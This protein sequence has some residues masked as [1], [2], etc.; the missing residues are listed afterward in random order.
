MDAERRIV[1]TGNSLHFVSFTRE[2]V[3]SSGVMIDFAHDSHHEAPFLRKTR[4]GK[5]IFG[6]PDH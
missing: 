4:K 5:H 2:W 6:N 1:E 3:V